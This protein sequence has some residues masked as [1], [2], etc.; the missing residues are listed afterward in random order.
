MQFRKTLETKVDALKVN[1]PR[2]NNI[3]FSFWQEQDEII[4][5][6]HA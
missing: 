3:F 4:L 2:W 6:V 1:E 5:N